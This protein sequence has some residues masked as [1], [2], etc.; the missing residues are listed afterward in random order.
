MRISVFGLGYVGAV[1]AACLARDGHEVIGC[2]IDPVKLDL[3]GRGESPIIEA[4][5]PELIS[6]GVRSGRLRVTN[7][8]RRAMAESTISLLCVGTPSDRHGAQDLTAVKRLAAQLGDALAQKPAFHGFVLRSTVAPGT[9]ETVLTPIIAER[10]GKTAGEDFAVAFQP[11]FLR[12]GVSIR[13]YDH[14]PY[15][16]VGTDHSGLSNDLR[17]LYGDLPAPFRVTDIRSAEALKMVANAFHALKITFANEVGRLTQALDVDGRAVMSLICEDR[18][19]N[20]SPAYLRPGFAFGGSC[21]PKDVRALEA[22]ARDHALSLPM[23]TGI[24]PSNQLQIEH[25]AQWVLQSGHR[26]VGILGLS[27]KSGTDDMRESPLVTLTERFIGKGL[28]LRI[29]DPKVN[30]ARLLGANKRYIEH[31]IPHIASLLQ[32]DAKSVIEHG[33]V[34]VVGLADEALVEA[35]E[36]YHRPDQLILDL[37]GVPATAGISARVQGVCW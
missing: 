30:L 13:D 9:T 33:Q 14:P 36:R 11:E 18:Q 21:L 10:S 27:F 16:V 4:G 24:L 17:S 2:D 6:N 23:L 29:Y 34:L 28:N 26:E 15:T 25:A 8:S 19:L 5:L 12:E 20:I 35:L 37:V 22:L 1:S 31:S 32:P 7:D 3:I